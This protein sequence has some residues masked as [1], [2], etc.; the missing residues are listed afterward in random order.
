VPVFEALDP[1]INV[2]HPFA[3]TVAF[4][5]DASTDVYGIYDVLELFFAHKE[6]NLTVSQ[7]AAIVL[8]TRAR[9]KY[10]PAITF[11]DPSARSR[12]QESGKELIELWREE[13]IYP[14]LGQNSR[15]LTYE[16]D[17]RADHGR[18]RARPPREPEHR[19]LPRVGVRRP[20][21]VDADGKPLHSF[22][23]EMV[24]Y[25]WRKPSMRSENAPPAEP[26]KRNDD[27]I[28]TQR[29]MVVGIPTWRGDGKR[30]V[31][32]T[33]PAEAAFPQRQL[34]RRHLIHVR[35]QLKRGGRGGRVGG[36]FPG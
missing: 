7:Q 4:L 11:I 34:L 31:E 16:R 32:D 30:P 1:G 5:N 17:A 26:V 10:R 22:G 6:P 20:R 2:D 35:K 23:N 29:Y 27:G 18:S 9:F 3:F 8:D 15:E 19:P 14:I 25:R 21:D 12:N 24:N 36:S 13:G 33:L 28:D